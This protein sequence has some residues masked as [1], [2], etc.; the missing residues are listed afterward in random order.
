[1]TPLT[2]TLV[3]QRDEFVKAPPQAGGGPKVVNPPK[4]RSF[5]L[6]EEDANYFKGLLFGIYGSGKTKAV[7]DLIL[8]GYKI[9][10]LSTDMGESGH[11][12]ITNWLTD[13]N[14]RDLLK[15]CHII[16]VSGY[17]ET[18]S[19]IDNPFRFCPWLKEFDPDFLVWDGFSTWQQVD[20]T[21]HIG[22]M[23][24]AKDN[25]LLE[26]GLVLDQRGYGAVRNATARKFNAFCRIH[27]ESKKWHK[28]FTAYEAITYKKIGDNKTEMVVESYKPMLSG[29]GGQL[30]LGGMDLILR[31]KVTKGLK[32]VDYTYV[33]RGH[34]N[35]AAKSRGYHLKDEEPADFLALW[36]KIK[37]NFAEGGEKVVT[38]S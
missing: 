21:E 37:A 13:H 34:E 1:M 10:V 16:P 23:N 6:D 18:E 27:G 3:K 24:S 33:T 12:T 30:V 32:G 25:D 36:N 15:N 31:C 17:E 22:D 38:S 5:R 26:S 29:A 4:K 7:A 19:F 28:L 8:G 9:A 11:S 35:M 2:S 14:R 20:V